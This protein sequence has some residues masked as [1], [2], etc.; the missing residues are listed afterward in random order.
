MKKFAKLLAVCL[1]VMA[2]AG[3]SLVTVNPEKITVATVG[4]ETITKA[5]FDEQFNAFLAQ[6]GYTQESEAIADQMT[7]LKESFIDQMVEQLVID[8]KVRELGLDQVTDEEKAEAEKSVDDWYQSQLEALIAEYE[9][10]ESV[11]DPEAQAKEDIENYLSYYGTSLDD[12]KAQEV[13]AIPSGKLYDYVTRDVVVTEEEAKLSYAEHVASD[14]ESYDGNLA[15]FVSAFDNG[16]LIYYVPEGAFYV[17]HILIGLTDEQK[18]EIYDLRNDDD[19][20]VAATADAKREEFLATIQA[21]ADA[22]LAAVEAGGD[23]DALIAEY[24]D[25]PGMT[26]DYYAD[27]YLTYV[28]NPNYVAE[29]TAACD[30]LTEDG[31]TTGLVASDFGYHI[32][33]RVSTKTPGEVPFEDVKDDLMDGMLSSAQEDAYNAMVDQ[34]ISEA[35]VEIKSNKL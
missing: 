14:K 30:G 7:E 15:S 12:M 28:G 13:E 16:Y 4:G 25:D 22:A 20:A 17:K 24:G 23:F 33:R 1:A 29:F 5:Q 34:W 35:N 11:A 9:K 2:L 8:Q 27:G 3:C 19:E 18:Q 10:D 31:M 21:E 32:I 26:Y 6:Y